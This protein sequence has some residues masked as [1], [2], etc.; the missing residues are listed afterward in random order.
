MYLPELLQ[1][2]TSRLREL[3]W[4]LSRLG[5]RIAFKRLPRGLF[6]CAGKSFRS[7]D[8]I[9]E[10]KEDLNH[11]SQETNLKSSHFLADKIERKISVLV[12]LYHEHKRSDNKKKSEWSP[13]NALTSR[14]Q[15]L[16][17]M[18]R[19]QDVLISQKNAYI[20]RMEH[21]QNNNQEEALSI[22]HE[23]GLIVQKLTKIK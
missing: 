9:K 15:W 18:Q 2:L 14:Q 6:Y 20:Q 16:E 11:L 23:I 1:Q 22:K 12:A 8:F 21:L 4:K 17:Q 13:I 19:D 5:E 7:S 3:E 10:I